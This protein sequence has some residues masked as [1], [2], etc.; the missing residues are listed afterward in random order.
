MFY[1][2]FFQIHCISRIKTKKEEE[3]E[4]QQLQQHFKTHQSESV[5]DFVNFWTLEH[6]YRFY[7]LSI[8][9]LQVENPNF[10]AFWISD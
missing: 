7:H 9:N 2:F 3:N 6:L 10:R 8:P 4:Q 5:L 1:L